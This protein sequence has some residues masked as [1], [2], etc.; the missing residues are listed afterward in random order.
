M[1]GPPLPPPWGGTARAAGRL[2]LAGEEGGLPVDGA[3]HGLEE[4]AALELVRRDL[5]DG[6]RGA[7]PGPGLVV[8]G[9]GQLHAGGGGGGVRHQ[10]GVHHLPGGLPATEIGRSAEF[11]WRNFSRMGIP[12]DLQVPGKYSDRFLQF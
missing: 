1:P 4:A 12:E 2:V 3:D 8:R 11:A 10:P 5:A 6:R 7:R 9:G